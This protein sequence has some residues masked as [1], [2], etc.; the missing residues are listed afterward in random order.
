MS[1]V[2]VK[3]PVGTAQGSPFS[4]RDGTT[5]TIGAGGLVVINSQYL[6]D[7]MNAGF[8]VPSSYTGAVAA[9]LTANVTGTQAG[10]TALGYGI[11]Q[12]ATSGAAAA[13]AAL[14]AAV[15]GAYVTVIN[16]GA[17][18]VQIF[19]SGT[20]TINGVAS[21]TGVTQTPSS[22]ITY[23]CAVAGQWRCTP[24]LGFSGN[25]ETTTVSAN[26]SANVTGT[27][28][29]ATPL[30]SMINSVNVSG[31]VN[32]AVLLPVSAPGMQITVGTI[33]ANA[34]NV[35]PQVNE[36][37]NGLGANLALNVPANKSAVFVCSVAGQWHGVLSA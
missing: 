11:N 18:T 35:Y 27:Q 4:T 3:A 12:I 9:N 15:P 5:Y 34:V 1:T 10:A 2:T 14:P 8:S 26:L 20:D 31:A 37:I 13:A 22:E 33:T 32:S 24:A 19:G 29:G 16:D 7:A 23:W 30:P 36:K 17:N 21:A 6:A 28:A 25:F